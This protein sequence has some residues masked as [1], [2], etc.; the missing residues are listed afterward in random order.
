MMQMVIS[1][2]GIVIAAWM[3]VRMRKIPNW[4]TF[5][6]ILTGFILNGYF[7]GFTGLKLSI[8]GLSLGILFLY[9][10]FAVGGMGAGDVKLLGALGSLLGPVLVFKIFLA[11]AVFG[12]IFSLIATLKARSI[13]NVFQGIFNQVFCLLTTKGVG[14]KEPLGIQPLV[15]IPYACAIAAGTL[16]VLLILK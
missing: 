1:I 2:I 16:F 3:D 14:V 4:L 6:L 8:F 13:R 10:P 5:S 15:G 11:S 7:D 9:I 12:G